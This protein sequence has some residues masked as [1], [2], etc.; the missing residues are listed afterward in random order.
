MTLAVPVSTGT[1]LAVQMKC[2]TDND[3]AAVTSIGSIKMIV[4]TQCLQPL[5]TKKKNKKDNKGEFQEEGD[6]AVLPVDPV[7]PVTTHTWVFDAGDTQVDVPENPSAQ[8][9][10]GWKTFLLP[11]GQD[12]KNEV[13]GKTA[14]ELGFSVNAAA[15][16]KSPAPLGSFGLAGDPLLTPFVKVDG[17]GFSRGFSVQW[18]NYRSSIVNPS[19]DKLKNLEATLFSFNKISAIYR[20]DQSEFRFRTPVGEVRVP[21]DN[22]DLKTWVHW[23][24]IY[25]PVAGGASVFRFGQLVGQANES[26]PSTPEGNPVGDTQNEIGI[27]FDIA[28]KSPGLSLWA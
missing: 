23:S 6:L 4:G 2:N 25:D 5:C 26:P 3:P 13:V 24:V 20:Q 7:L 28:F 14:I 22:Y 10:D 15:G 11:V 1:S 12:N 27:C 17:H 18:W 9:Q 19:S 8:Q 16:S 21:V